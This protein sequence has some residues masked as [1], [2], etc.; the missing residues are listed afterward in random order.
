MDGKVWSKNTEASCWIFQLP[1]CWQAG[2]GPPQKKRD[3]RNEEGDY[4]DKKIQK[5]QGQNVLYWHQTAEGVRAQ[6]SGLQLLGLDVLG[7]CV[8][9]CDVCNC[10]S[11]S[12]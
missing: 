9:W 12:Q 5:Q 3:A 11:T 7:L 4:N 1:C 2:P 6:H 8:I 10:D